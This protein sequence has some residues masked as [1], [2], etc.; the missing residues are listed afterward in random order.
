M[1]YPSFSPLSH[2]RF[3]TTRVWQFA[4]TVPL[5]AILVCAPQFAK[6]QVSATLPP[7]TVFSSDTPRKVQDGT[8]ALVGHYEPTQ[9]LRLTLGL[10]PPHLVEERQFLESLQTKGSHDFHQFLTA[11]EWTKRFDPSLEDEQA[12]MDWATAQ[13][14]TVTHRFPNRLIVD[15]EGTAGTI[16]KAFGVTINTYQVGSRTGFSNDRD[17][18]IPSSLSSILLSVGGLNN[19]DVAHPA[20]RNLPEPAFPDYAPGPS[21]ST[22]RSAGQ[23]GDRS[24]LPS[25]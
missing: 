8:A 13:G 14:L 23:N 11:E 20:N 18:Q 2:Y 15:V 4:L 12:V 5:F 17:L 6:A 3:F 25:R 1:K 22:G 24:K 16:E 9:R 7:S 19:L 21:V 10:L